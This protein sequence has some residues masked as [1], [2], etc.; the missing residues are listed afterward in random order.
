VSSL[1]GERVSEV[2]VRG[3][4]VSDPWFKLY[5]DGQRLFFT[6]TPP[7]LSA[8]YWDEERGYFVSV[9]GVNQ[10]DLLIR[11]HQEDCRMCG[12]RCRGTA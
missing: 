9:K 4:D 10:Y 11:A 1:Q 5:Q 8:F 2:P 7:F 3:P 12:L 6:G